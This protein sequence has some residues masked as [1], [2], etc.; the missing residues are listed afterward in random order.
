[1]WEVRDDTEL[2]YVG[3]RGK[4]SV[5]R[6]DRVFAPDASSESVYAAAAK[7]IVGG[8]LKGVNGTAGSYPFSIHSLHSFIHSFIHHHH[9]YHHHHRFEPPSV[10][11]SLDAVSTLSLSLSRHRCLQTVYKPPPRVIR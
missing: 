5:H 8:A 7:D 2:R 3:G 9:H 11:T 10:H 6:A 4:N 1:M